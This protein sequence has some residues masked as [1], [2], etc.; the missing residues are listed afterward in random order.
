[1]F[2]LPKTNSK[3]D[4]TFSTYVTVYDLCPRP[5]RSW[6]RPGRPRHCTYNYRISHIGTTQRSDPA[7]IQAW[8]IVHS[9]FGSSCLLFVTM[10][11]INGAKPCSHSKETC[12][13]QNDPIDHPIVRLCII[14]I[15]GKDS[16][17]I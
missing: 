4:S 6:A 7:M 13:D 11:F 16:E 2:A 5:A 17:F 1:M 3:S 8:Q 10:Y 14:L 15:K 12:T 9:G